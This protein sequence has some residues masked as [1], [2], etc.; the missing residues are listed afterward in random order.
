LLKFRALNSCG[1]IIDTILHRSKF[2]S[3]PVFSTFW[4][5]VGLAAAACEIQSLPRQVSGG[6]GTTLDCPALF[7]WTGGTVKCEVSE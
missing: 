4:Q 6:Q 5:P 1:L 2:P 7:G 3:G